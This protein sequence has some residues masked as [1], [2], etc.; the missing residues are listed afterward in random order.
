MWIL[1]SWEVPDGRYR[2]IDCLMSPGSV[3]EIP[4]RGNRM[5]M[6]PCRTCD[7]KGHVADRRKGAAE[8][9]SCVKEDIE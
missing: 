8:R 6:R 4:H 7:G 1:P 5:T 3:Y 2:C 9:R